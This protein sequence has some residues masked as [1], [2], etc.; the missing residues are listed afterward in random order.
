MKII[1]VEINKT[2]EFLIKKLFHLVNSVIITAPEGYFC[3]NPN[4]LCDN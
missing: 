2:G 4:G 3:H 1:K